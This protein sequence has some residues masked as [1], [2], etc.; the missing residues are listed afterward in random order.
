MAHI[1]IR[2]AAMSAILYTTSAFQAAG[3][4]PAFYSSKSGL[5][6]HR[7]SV[8]RSKQGACGGLMMGKGKGVPVNLRGEFQKR[9][10]LEQMQRQMMGDDSDGLPVFMLY[11]RSKVAKLWCVISSQF[12]SSSITMN[13]VISS[14]SSRASYNIGRSLANLSRFQPIS[15]RFC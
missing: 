12:I 4:S 5:T 1:F 8:L 2:M 10:Q 6:D 15:T 9:S 7:N 11:T 13:S 14:K 3:F